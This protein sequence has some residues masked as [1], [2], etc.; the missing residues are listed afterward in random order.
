MTTLMRTNVMNEVKK[1]TDQDTVDSEDLNPN[2]SGV[3]EPQNKILYQFEMNPA[4]KCLE[5]LEETGEKKKDHKTFFIVD[6]E[7]LTPNISEVVEQQNKTSYQIETNLVKKCLEMLEEID[8]KKDD[9]NKMR[10]ST[11]GADK[12]MDD[13]QSFFGQFDESVKH[14]I[15]KNT[16]DNFEIAELTMSNTSKYEEE[17]IGL[18]ECIDR[19]KEDLNDIHYITDESMDSEYLNFNVDLEDPPLYTSQEN[20]QQNK[21]LRMIKRV[22]HKIHKNTIDDFEI[23]ELN[24]SNTSKS[25]EKQ[26]NLKECID[27]MKEDLNDTHYITDESLDAGYLISNK[28]NVDLEDPPLNTS[29]ENQQ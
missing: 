11:D 21:I 15:H 2:I 1:N 6:S 3:V 4:K 10:P 23:V 29:Q 16:T 25:E 24:K 18:K 20:Q 26:I 22:K 13:N 5:L 14:E 19:M 8:E 27:R 9:S 12:M 17:Q 7:N 28:D